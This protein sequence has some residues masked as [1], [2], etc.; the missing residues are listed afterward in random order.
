MKY[1]LPFMLFS[2]FNCW[3]Q[4]DKSKKLESNTNLVNTRKSDSTKVINLVRDFFQAFDNRDYEKLEKILTP[5]SKIVHYNGVTTD[6]EE[7]LNI[8]KNTENWYPRKRNLSN[9]EFDGDENFAFVGVVN[10]VTFSL[11]N[12]EKV[13]SPYKETWIF[14][15]IDN[16]WHVIRTHYSKIVEETHSEDVESNPAEKN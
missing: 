7:M 3:S 4:S 11:P 2:I 6:T 9:F 1:I 12:N 13:Y 16:N 14:K 10:K 15:K 5:S 8:L